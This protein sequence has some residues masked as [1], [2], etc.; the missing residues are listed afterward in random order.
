M[1]GTTQSIFSTGRRAS[2]NLLEICYKQ[3]CDLG[4]SS[5]EDGLY[6]F[7]FFFFELFIRSQ[8]RKSLYQKSR[9]WITI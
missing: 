8:S 5:W 9:N 3:L 4:L 6:F 7:F 2:K 1:P